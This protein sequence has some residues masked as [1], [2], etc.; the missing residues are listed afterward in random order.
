[1]MRTGSADELWQGFGPQLHVLHGVACLAP[2]LIKNS[3]GLPRSKDLCGLLLHTPQLLQ[4]SKLPHILR[5]ERQEL[6]AGDLHLVPCLVCKPL[7]HHG[8]LAVVWPS[9]LRFQACN[10]DAVVLVQARW[11]R[12]TE[13]DELVYLGM[14][15]CDISIANK[16]RARSSEYPLQVYAM[17]LA[18]WTQEG[19]YLLQS[20]SVKLVAFTASVAQ[21]VKDGPCL[22]RTQSLNSF[23]LDTE[24]FIFLLTVILGDVVKV[25][26]SHGMSNMH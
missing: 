19:G 10:L 25:K 5:L 26:T 11:T 12:V 13:S 22:G 23:D 8:F 2:M 24:Q 9:A 14:E 20:S 3:L 15:S 1:M 4:I 17:L 7:G 6:L 18:D 16:H 21:G